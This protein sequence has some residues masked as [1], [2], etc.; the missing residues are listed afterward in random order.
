MRLNFSQR[1]MLRVETRWRKLKILK[2]LQLRPK[3]LRQSIDP[4]FA[5]SSSNLISPG[6]NRLLAYNRRN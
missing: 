2:Q 3:S 4:G 6:M 5:F 1:F